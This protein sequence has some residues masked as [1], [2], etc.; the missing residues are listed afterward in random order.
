MDGELISKWFAYWRPLELGLTPNGHANGLMLTLGVF[1]ARCSGGYVLYR[2]TGERTPVRSERIVGAAAARA[3]TISNFPFVGHEASTVYWYLL[4]AV[5]QGGVA[6]TTAHQI[7]RVEFDADGL[8]VGPRPNA[9]IALTVDR[10]AGGGFCLR[11]GYDPAGQETGPASFEI[12]SDA[13]SPGQIDYAA[14][15]GSVR[16]QP[17]RALYEWTSHAFVD[18]TRVRWGVRARSPRGVLEDN[19]ASVTAEADA[20]GPPGHADVAA[21]RTGDL[22]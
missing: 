2:W 20:A 9:P 17:G 22:P 16:F 19:M 12:Y 7:A 6:E 18:G 4:R 3:R 8:P 11:W 21:T 10:L 1:W 13:F 5:G 15:V 14:A